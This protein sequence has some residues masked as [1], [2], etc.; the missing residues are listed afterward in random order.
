[1]RGSA[2]HAATCERRPRL[3]TFLLAHG[4]PMNI[5]TNTVVTL[6]FELYDADGVL[7]ESTDEPITY[8]H[9]GHSGMLP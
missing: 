1:M 3:P 2:F 7:L 4:S 9:G 8:L 5:F 6:T